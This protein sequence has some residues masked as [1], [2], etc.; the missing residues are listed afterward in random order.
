MREL[1][2]NPP[3]G[4]FPPTDGPNWECTCPQPL[5]TTLIR[6]APIKPGINERMRELLSCLVER[7]SELSVSDLV[8]AKPTPETRQLC[9]I[10]NNV[11]KT[12]LSISKLQLL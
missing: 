9:I 11:L 5:R 12:V 2:S 8:D 6:N 10:L 1:E 7:S 3:N 4:A